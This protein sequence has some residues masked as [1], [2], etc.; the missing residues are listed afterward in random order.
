M[1]TGFRHGARVVAAAALIM[2]SVFA[3]F[4]HAELTT[5]RP[6]GFALAIG[7]LIDAFVVR[8]TAMPAIMFLLGERAWYLPRW[9]G[10][11]PDL[12]VEGTRLAAAIEQDGAGRR[13]TSA[14][15][16]PVG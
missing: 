14:P 11:L 12:D 13:S 9:L 10:W 15:R 1:H 6:I 3:G 4:I 2:T 8:M 16:H 5:V 7:V